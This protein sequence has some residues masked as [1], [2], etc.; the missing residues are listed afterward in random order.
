[1]R[2]TLLFLLLASFITTSQ[3]Q[4]KDSLSQK[5][6]TTD[7]YQKKEGYI[8]GTVLNASNDVVLQNVNIVNLNN[9]KGAI[10]DEDGRFEIQAKADDTLFFSYLGYKTL[11]IRVSN[12]WVQYGDVKIKMTEVAIALE[13]VIVQEIQLTGYLEIDARNI[14]IYNNARYSIS[15]LSTGYETG[16]SQSG[17]INRAL[18]A[19]FNPADFL[20]NIFSKKPQQLRK[21]RKMKEDDKVRS[22]LEKKFDRETLTALLQVER[23]D[24]DE[25]LRNCSYSET[26]ITTANDLQI[27]DAIAECYEE[28]RVLNRD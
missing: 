26:F 23:V 13:E 11:Q 10:T 15:G 28:Y 12:D 14:P 17:A 24:I 5:E 2:L 16:N 18:S 4:V 3:A 21:L 22:L 8:N 27:L 9:V 25:I 6:T 20:Y 7:K 19:I 1:M